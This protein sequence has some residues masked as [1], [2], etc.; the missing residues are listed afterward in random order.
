MPDLGR[1]ASWR[2]ENMGWIVVTARAAF[3]VWLMAITVLAVVPHADDGLM[4]QTNVTASGMEKHILGYFVGAWLLVLAQ[5]RKGAKGG[6]GDPGMLEYCNAGTRKMM[7][8]WMSGGGVFGYSVV[9]EG[10]QAFLPY[11]TFNPY[12]IIGN[13]VG[14]GVFCLIFLAQSRGGAKREVRHWS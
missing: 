9:L 2:D 12:D 14:V 5:R 4:V 11:R 7:G 6:V 8:V 10:V 3:G 13:G 1:I